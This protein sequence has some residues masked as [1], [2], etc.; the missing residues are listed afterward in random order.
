MR[1][2]LTENGPSG[3][4]PFTEG[5]RNA[6]PNGLSLI[7]APKALIVERYS[8]EAQFFLEELNGATG[9]SPYFAQSLDEGL[10]SMKRNAS[11]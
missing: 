3:P 9:C 8:M 10:R 1:T 6:R 11:P 5:L 2:L 7:S 4:H